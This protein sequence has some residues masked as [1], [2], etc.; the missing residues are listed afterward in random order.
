MK[1]IHNARTKCKNLKLANAVNY[2]SQSIN[3]LKSCPFLTL[4]IAR[5]Q[6]STN[7]DKTIFKMNSKFRF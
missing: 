6:K 2:G 7:F 1:L 3:V 5:V 4:S